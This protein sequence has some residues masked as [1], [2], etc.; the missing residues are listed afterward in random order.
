VNEYSND[1]I[2]IL[3]INTFSLGWPVMAV[4]IVRELYIHFTTD[5]ETLQGPGGFNFLKYA[6]GAPLLIFIMCTVHTDIS[7][8][9][10]NSA[11]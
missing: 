1:I 5:L 4:V 9:F 3:G 11:E 10:K 8:D 7:K 2:S 6:I